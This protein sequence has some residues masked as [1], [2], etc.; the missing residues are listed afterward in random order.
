MPNRR[1]LAL[2]L[3]LVC[4]AVSIPARGEPRR[5]VSLS[6]PDLVDVARATADGDWLRVTDV[7]LDSRGTET[8]LEVR[9]FELFAPGARVVVH[10][11][12]G[13]TVLP[14]PNNVY[15]EGFLDGDVTGRAAISVLADGEVRGLLAGGGR[16][17]VLSNRLDG[18]PL[19]APLAREV[20]P[21]ELAADAAEFHCEADGLSSA[22][23]VQH[24]GLPDPFPPPEAVNAPGATYE[25]T[26]A[27][28]SDFEYFQRFGNTTDAVNYAADLIAYANVVYVPEI[29][30][31][32]RMGDVSIWTTSAD[33]W[34]QTSTGCGL[35]EFGRNW[36]DNHDDIP[37]TIAHFLSGKNN[38]GGIAW[39]GVLCSDEFNY[40]ITVFGCSG[41]PTVDNYGGDYGY[42]G[43]LDANFDLGNPHVVWDVV[44]TSHEMGHNFNSPHTHCYAGIG[45]SG[46]PVDMCFG[47]EDGC[48]SGPTSLPG[49]GCPGP[50]NGCG[51]IMSYCHLLSGG[52]ANI[53]WTFGDGHP[54]GVLPDR[55]PDRMGAFVVSTN[56]ASPACLPLNGNEIFSDGFET[57]NT[58]AWDQTTN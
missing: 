27:I 14:P 24:A 51:T 13:E 18:A 41:M 34:V 28:E 43:D 45:G 19:T 11:A 32:L 6:A 48:Y 15:F 20:D 57:G 23:E 1:A 31:E 46:S 39:V 26:V 58:G 25:V 29:D 16:Y 36:N 42:S 3:A 53:S 9:R 8:A 44:V 50:G 2:T 52:I 7:A 22:T 56:N 38:G 37:R 4:V 30:A 17:W 12:S 21:A 33:P 40:D 49:P 55:V 10:G 47:G 35:F 5:S 54:Y